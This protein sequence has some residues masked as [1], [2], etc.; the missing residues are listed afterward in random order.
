MSTSFALFNLGGGEI[1]LILA[2]ILILYGAR[3][4]PESA[5]GLGADI[6]EFGREKTGGIRGERQR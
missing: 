2:L 1:I 6:E 3:K 4:F 5:K